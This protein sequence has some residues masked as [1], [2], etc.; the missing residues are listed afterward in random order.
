MYSLLS[1][2]LD[3]K[4]S[5]LVSSCIYWGDVVGLFSYVMSWLTSIVR[6]NMRAFPSASTSVDPAA[7][8]IPRSSGAPC[9]TLLTVAK[10]VV[11]MVM[12]IPYAVGKAASCKRIQV[13]VPFQAVSGHS[14]GLAY[15][16]K[17]LNLLKTHVPDCIGRQVE[18]L[19]SDNIMVRGSSQL[20]DFPWLLQHGSLQQQWFQLHFPAWSCCWSGQQLQGKRRLLSQPGWRHPGR[21]RQSPCKGKMVHRGWSFWGKPGSGWRS[22][23]KR[24]QCQSQDKEQRRSPELPVG[25]LGAQPH[26]QR[27]RRQVAVQF[28]AGMPFGHQWLGLLH[29]RQARLWGT[30]GG[31]NTQLC[32]YFICLSYI[33]C[34]SSSSASP[35]S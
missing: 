24:S 34:C 1:Y 21:R 7:L 12:L 5:I 19:K 9:R 22:C 3:A 14:P 29:L 18:L 25:I 15:W 23:W 11:A 27:T 31:Y 4:E 33:Q 20:Q 35:A 30:S 10:A 8:P 6:V 32:F 13:I 28:L 17:Q 16:S 2:K 26:L